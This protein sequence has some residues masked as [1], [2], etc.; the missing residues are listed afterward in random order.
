MNTD[1]SRR[2]LIR[3]ITG[4]AAGATL[5]ATGEVLLVPGTA[6]AADAS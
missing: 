2:T 3:G 5:L 1:F 4:V 6:Q